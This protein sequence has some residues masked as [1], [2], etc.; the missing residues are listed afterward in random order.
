MI[1]L[2]TDGADKPGETGT[3]DAPWLIDAGSRGPQ[4]R[5]ALGDVPLGT[6][7]VIDLRRHAG[8]ELDDTTLPVVRIPI[9]EDRAAAPSTRTLVEALVL[10]QGS[11]L[12]RAVSAIAMA[13]GPVVVYSGPGAVSSGLVRA[14]TLLAAGA[15][16]GS[17]LAAYPLAT[18]WTPLPSPPLS[19]NALAHALRVIDRY[20]GVEC[21]LLRNGVRVEEFH[22]LR[23]KLEERH[24]EP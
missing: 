15:G 5:G 19:A 17:V 23:D 16:V 12:A 11:Q 9:D 1:A 14:L 7:L 3:P 18:A 4:H 13:D 24:D 2:R 8:T 10:T 22:A 6:A 20:N 21:F